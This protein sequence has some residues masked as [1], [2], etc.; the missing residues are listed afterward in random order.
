MRELKQACDRHG[1][2]FGFYYSHAFDWGE[3]DGAGNDWD[4]QNPGGD[5]NLH[6]G[7]DWWQTDAAA[8][9][10]ACA[11]TSTARRSPSCAS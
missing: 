2:K 3:A 7:R 1:L 8:D 11:G 6:G 4:Y 10:A 5:L 9:P